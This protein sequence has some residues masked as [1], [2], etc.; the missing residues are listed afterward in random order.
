MLEADKLAWSLRSVAVWIG[1]GQLHRVLATQATLL[2]SGGGATFSKT[3]AV[4]AVF[5]A[6]PPRDCLGGAAIDRARLT[7]MLP[8]EPSCVDL[9]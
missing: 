1:A 8:A 3:L 2:P 7:A 5:G 6:Q 9:T 4:R